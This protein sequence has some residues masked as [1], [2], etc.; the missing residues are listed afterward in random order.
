MLAIILAIVMLASIGPIRRA[1]R[2]QVKEL[3]RYE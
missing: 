2:M 1:T 3:L